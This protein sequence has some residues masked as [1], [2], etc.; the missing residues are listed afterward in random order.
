MS[1][2][3]RG[4]RRGS[5]GVTIRA[6]AA[7]A[8]VSAMTVSNV[9]NGTGKMSDA[10]RQTVLAAIDTLGFQPNQAARA[11][12]GAEALRIGFVH[13]RVN[14]GF[15]SAM[16]IGALNAGALL[17]AQLL[18]RAVPTVDAEGLAETV[19]SLCDNGV[20]GILLSP[21]FAEMLP[22]SAL[23]AELAVPVAAVAAGQP[24]PGLLTV[25]VDDR[26]AVRQMV[27]RLLA[28]GHRR[29]GLIAGPSAHSS[30]HAR[31]LGYC[32]SLA[33]AGLP[34]DEALIGAG[35]FSFDSALPAAEHLLSLPDRPTAIFASNDEMAAAVIVSATRRGLAVPQDVAVAGFN[36]D[37]I[38]S[39]TW[40]P[41]T[42]VR[43][44]V[45]QLAA[46][47]L[48]TLAEHIRGRAVPDDQLLPFEIVPRR[49]TGE[50]P[51][52]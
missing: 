49:S 25:R 12:A 15:L 30:A 37:S 19:R 50:L 32:D 51:P 17:G 23:L 24:L 38:A 2:R 43:Q 10:T 33:A 31:R 9:I 3:T 16:L 13:S 14:N 44:P 27:D 7:H 45:E 39:Q 48:R 34:I 40:P 20:K 1:D 11:L 28:L 52:A 22:G 5:Q 46:Q 4:K 18:V 29:I 42:T 35:R 41:I 47:A 26:A 8:G 21:P 36:D 6:V